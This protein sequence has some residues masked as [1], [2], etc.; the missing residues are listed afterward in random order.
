MTASALNDVERRFLDELNVRGIR[1]MVVGLTAA[2]A[3]GA[4]SVTRDID[5]W[6]ENTG[7]LRIYPAAR[8]AGGAWISGFG[9]MPPMLGG[10]LADRFDVV[11]DISG[12]EGFDAEYARSKLVEIDG[13]SVRV[14]PIDRIIAS[15]RAANRP[16]DLAAIQR[17]GSAAAGAALAGMSQA[18]AK[19]IPCQRVRPGRGRSWA[20]EL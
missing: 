12:L 5:L 15:K 13:V 16:K 6:F 10:A 1:Y 9:M 18:A 14:L 7:D 2:I 8:A 20:M 19:R 3:Q 11:L 4:N 17:A